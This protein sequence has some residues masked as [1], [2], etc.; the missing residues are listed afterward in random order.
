MQ[1]HTSPDS[2]SAARAPLLPRGL[3]DELVL[4]IIELCASLD[5]DCERE[6][7]FADL[8]LVSR[9]Y[10]QAADRHLYSRFTITREVYEQGASVNSAAQTLARRPELRQHV[11]S[12]VFSNV[13]PSFL[14][15]HP[16]VA[17]LLILM[18]NVEELV[19]PYWDSPGLACLLASAQAR[20]PRLVVDRWDISAEIVLEAHPQ[21]F[22]AL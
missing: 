2:P 20:I 7:T 21:V 12:L 11:R 19:K 9:R 18:P 22:S 5:D 15:E 4:L 1:Q 17:A 16:S 10:K 14:E 13:G 8:C 3:P 6:R